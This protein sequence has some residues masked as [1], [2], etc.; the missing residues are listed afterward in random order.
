MSVLSENGSALSDPV[1]SYPN[2]HASTK[3][4]VLFYKEKACFTSAVINGE[5]VYRVTSFK[6]FGSIFD[7]DLC[8]DKSRDFIY[9]KC[10]QRLY[11]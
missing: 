5:T 1:F 11:L 8:F 9:K 10:L 2:E 6:Y 7:N 3:E 4:M